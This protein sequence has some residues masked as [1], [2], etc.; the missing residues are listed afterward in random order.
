MLMGWLM[1]SI[2][3][4][5]WQ[6][7]IMNDQTQESAE[8]EYRIWVPTETPRGR[9][10]SVQS[11][12]RLGRHIMHAESPDQSEFYFEVLAYEGLLDHGALVREQQ[13]FLRENSADGT[14]SEVSHGTLF[15]LEGTIFDFG[16]T[17]QNQWKERRFFFVDGPNR[18]YRIVHDPTSELNIRAFQRLQLGKRERVK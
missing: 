16:G 18:T 4:G 14:I 3:G 15:H 1:L 9:S 8:Y 11:E 10:V 12:E 13:A 17:L 2:Y 5:G 6:V 7:E